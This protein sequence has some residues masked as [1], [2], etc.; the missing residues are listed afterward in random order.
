M[1][2]GKSLLYDFLVSGIF[3]TAK[4]WPAY[5]KLKTIEGK[6]YPCTQWVF[7]LSIKNTKADD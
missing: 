5:V 1:E 4:Q 6:K 3:T 2:V 7:I